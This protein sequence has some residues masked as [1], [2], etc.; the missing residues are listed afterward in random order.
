MDLRLEM[1]PMLAVLTA[2][3]SARP[4]TRRIFEHVH[5]IRG[6]SHNR[7]GQD[8][9]AQ[10]QGRWRRTTGHSHRFLREKSNCEAQIAAEPR[11]H[12]YNRTG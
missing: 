9:Q 4:C 5:E 1:I 6:G 3:G 12:L 10:K 7:P 2:C 11:H 8:D